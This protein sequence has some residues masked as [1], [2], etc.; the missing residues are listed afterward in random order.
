[1]NR[2]DARGAAGG[3]TRRD[4]LLRT[5]LAAGALTLGGEPDGLWA[6]MD[7]HSTLNERTYRTGPYTVTVRAHRLRPTAGAHMFDVDVTF[8][9]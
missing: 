1:M 5:G 7:A 3:A 9:E 2:R 4:F 8:G 6:A